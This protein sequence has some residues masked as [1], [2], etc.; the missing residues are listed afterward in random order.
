MA[1]D[2]YVRGIGNL[3]IG[4]D[5]RYVVSTFLD[6]TKIRPKGLYYG[7]IG[8]SK[9]KDAAI[10]L[11]KKTDIGLAEDI[12]VISPEKKIVF[13]LTGYPQPQ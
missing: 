8:S 2:Y 9:S 1:A 7:Y 12:I 6:R 13:S 3:T 11:A 5:D 4:R 10:S